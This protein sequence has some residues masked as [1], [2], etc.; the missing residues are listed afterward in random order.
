MRILQWTAFSMTKASRGLKR[1]VRVNDW[2]GAEYFPACAAPPA[3]NE[4]SDV[5]NP[6]RR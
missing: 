5:W 6:A 3:R 2:P 1:T 4:T